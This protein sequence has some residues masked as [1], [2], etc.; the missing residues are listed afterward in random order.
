MMMEDKAGIKFNGSTDFSRFRTKM[1]AFG[2][3]KKGFDTAL[4]SDLNITA[5]SLDE[6]VNKVLRK[7]AWSYLMIA[8]DG[9]ALQ[10]VDNLNPQ[11]PYVARQMLI[12]RYDPADVEAY[13]RLN[14]EFTLYTME[15]PYDNP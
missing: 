14:Q 7:D 6:T 13:A 2:A 11:N 1:L 3:L 10:L 8:L 15:D 12:Q 9:A 5:G 4:L